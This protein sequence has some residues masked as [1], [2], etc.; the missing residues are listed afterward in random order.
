MIQVRLWTRSWLLLLLQRGEHQYLAGI[1]GWL[2]EEQWMINCVWEQVLKTEKRILNT[3]TKPIMSM[4]SGVLH[5]FPEN[6]IR[7]FPKWKMGCNE[8]TKVCHYLCCGKTQIWTSLEKRSAWFIVFRNSAGSMI[9]IWK[10]FGSI[11]TPPTAALLNSEIGLSLSW[12]EIH[13]ERKCLFFV[14]CHEASP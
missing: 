8:G 9:I 5:F 3:S 12:A 2:I 1:W 6:A 11:G 10:K 13:E 14:F 4:R 7:K